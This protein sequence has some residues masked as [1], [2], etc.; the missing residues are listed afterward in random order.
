LV[1]RNSDM[2]EDDRRDP[3]PEEAYNL[4]FGIGEE[5]YLRKLH[6]E[7]KTH[8][9]L[10][11]RTEGTAGAK[12]TPSARVKPRHVVAGIAGVTAIIAT[13]IGHAIGSGS[14][15]TAGDCVVTNPS[16]LTDWDIKKVACS[17]P[18]Q[19]D[20]YKVTSVQGGS[21]GGCGIEYTTFRDD[22]EHKT[23]CLA[24]HYSFNAPS[25]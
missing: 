19:G 25:G 7:G 3:T 24:Q 13:I 17:N 22:P 20:F 10:G 5:E 12:P 6:A 2:T 18:P 11:S 16:A 9:L 1:R 23:Y 21:D 4:Q 15:I 14:S 8:N